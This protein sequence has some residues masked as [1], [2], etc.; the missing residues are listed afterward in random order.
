MCVRSYHALM[1]SQQPM[2]TSD[3][4]MALS[5]VAGASLVGYLLWVMH[6]VWAAGL[7]Y[8]RIVGAQFVGSLEKKIVS[9]PEKKAA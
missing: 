3:P 1:G 9:S 4:M 8:G 5:P 7:V 6:L 2:V